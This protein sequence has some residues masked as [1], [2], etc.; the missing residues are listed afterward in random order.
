MTFHIQWVTLLCNYDIYTCIKCYDHTP[1]LMT[2][3]QWKRY[4]AFIR[5]CCTS[6]KCNGT[7]CGG[8][9]RGD[10]KRKPATPQ[11]EIWAERS[12][13]VAWN[14]YGAKIPYRYLDRDVCRKKWTESFQGLIYVGARAQIIQINNSHTM[15]HG[16][17]K[18]GK[19]EGEKTAFTFVVVFSGWFLYFSSCDLC[20]F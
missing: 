2:V 11:R 5:R 20:I 8:A 4:R 15:Q 6:W 19:M 10:T 1:C 17:I 9:L 13:Y 7:D 16:G 14:C 3:M 18:T 12:L